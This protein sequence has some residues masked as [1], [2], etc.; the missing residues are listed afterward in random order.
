MPAASKPLPA[1]EQRLAERLLDFERLD[2][3]WPRGRTAIERADTGRQRQE[4]LYEII[5]LRQRIATSRAE[6]LAD[7]AVQLRRL[8]VMAEE[9]T[10]FIAKSQI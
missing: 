2:E 9:V 5:T 1:L 6:T 3:A 10:W 7:A 4:A 8:V